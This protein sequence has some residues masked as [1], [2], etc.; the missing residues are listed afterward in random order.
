MHHEAHLGHGVEEWKTFN[1]SWKQF[2]ELKTNVKCAFFCAL[3]KR[4]T[5]RKISS[6]NRNKHV[7]SVPG[8]RQPAS[9]PT[10]TAA[11]TTQLQCGSRVRGQNPAAM[12]V[13]IGGKSSPPYRRML[14]PI[15]AVKTG[16][17][18][19]SMFEC[20]QYYL[21]RAVLFCP[22]MIPNPWRQKIR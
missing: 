22:F 10:S 20:A 8:A 6:K 12:C 21:I 7:Y 19:I 18:L 16:P 1:D 3:S 2:P 13:G 14:D 5:A 15:P 9:Q 17:M 4:K 11:T